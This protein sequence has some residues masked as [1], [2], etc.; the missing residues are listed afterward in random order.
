MLSIVSSSPPGKEMGAPSWSW[1]RL[2][3]ASPCVHE[4]GERRRP[5][6]PALSNPSLRQ[7]VCLRVKSL[8]RQ[9]VPCPYT[10]VLTNDLVF[11]ILC[12]SAGG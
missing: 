1:C 3:R 6:A 2:T 9:E 5:P 8:V 12:Y 4:K 10:N 7:H 11:Q